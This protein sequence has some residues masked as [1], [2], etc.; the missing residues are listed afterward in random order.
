MGY[1]PLA[2]RIIFYNVFKNKTIDE[3]TCII[4]IDLMNELH[5]VKNRPKKH[6]ITAI[7]RLP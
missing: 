7:M 6:T 2:A 5:N 1:V 4:I 3:E